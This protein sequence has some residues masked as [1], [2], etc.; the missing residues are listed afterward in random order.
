MTKI[1]GIKRYDFKDRQGNVVKGYKFHVNEEEKNTIG[2]IAFSFNLGDEK[3]SSIVNNVP[4]LDKLLGKQ[5]EVFY[6][7]YGKAD[8]IRLIS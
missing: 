5:I 8:G 3:V 7:K 6:N 1:V 2:V 4:T